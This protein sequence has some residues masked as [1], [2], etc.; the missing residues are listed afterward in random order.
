MEIA[1]Q[2]V[3]ISGGASGMGAATAR[4][5]RQKGAHIVIFDRNEAQAHTL[6]EAVQGHAF[7][8][9]I[10]DN[11]ALE[12]AFDTLNTLRLS[13]RVC[14]NCAGISYA[15]RLLGKE[16]LFPLDAFNE[17][18]QVNLVATFNLLRLAAKSMSVLSPLGASQERGVIINTASIAAFEGQVGQVAYS[19]SKGGVVAMALPAARELARFGIRVMTIAPGF[20]DTPMTQSMP[21]N[22][23]QQLLEQVS[24]PPRFATPEEYALLAGQIIE[25]PY[26]NGEVIRLDGAARMQ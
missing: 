17:V 24:F 25:N 3:L 26:L 22:I 7:K 14:I 9:D 18:I 19:A 1:Q 12:A 15:H 6:A 20:V 5:L 10:T 8:V 11:K 4:Y 13:P 21:E 2:V 23:Q 16:A